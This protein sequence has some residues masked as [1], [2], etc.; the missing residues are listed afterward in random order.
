MGNIQFYDLG[1]K[2]GFGWPVSH[3]EQVIKLGRQL[4]DELVAR[5]LLVSS[6]ADL[7]VIT[8]ASFVH[9]IGR[10]QEAIGKGEHNE[11]GLATLKKELGSAASEDEHNQLVLYCVYHHRG[12]LWKEASSDK[13]VSPHL[14]ARA[15]CLCGI[16]RIAD[17]LDH[18]PPFDKPVMG[19]K[20]ESLGD[21]IDAIV[22]QVE[23]RS[24]KEKGRVE[25]Y[26]D[27]TRREKTDLFKQAFGLREVY[28]GIT[29]G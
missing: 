8:D 3:C 16:F 10:S 22:C 2:Y 7:Q 4:Y 23:P 29:N 9:D 1:R 25:R 6:D 5:R 17:G 24:K 28:F 26:C 15:K 19:V 11:K 12:V 21:A 14:L 27:H 18:G 13:E 20:L